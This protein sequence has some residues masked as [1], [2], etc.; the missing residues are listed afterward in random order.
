LAHLHFLV[1]VLCLSSRVTL[2]REAYCRGDGAQQRF[3]KWYECLHLS[4]PLQR[5]GLCCAF[6]IT[7]I[8]FAGRQRVH[9]HTGVRFH[10]RRLRPNSSHRSTPECLALRTGT[11]RERICATLPRP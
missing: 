4:S 8:W 2:R 10:L 7:L 3:S 11:A 1:L 5:T 9:R 6:P